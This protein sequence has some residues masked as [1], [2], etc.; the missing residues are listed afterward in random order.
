MSDVQWTVVVD[1]LSHAFRREQRWQ[2]MYEGAATVS[3]MCGVHKT[4]WPRWMRV[5]LDLGEGGLPERYLLDE[6]PDSAVRCHRCTA[7]DLDDGN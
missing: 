1:G 4:M 6:C 5:Q 2:R 7:G 3:M